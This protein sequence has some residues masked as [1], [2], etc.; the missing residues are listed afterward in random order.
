V[1][2]DLDRAGAGPGRSSE[3]SSDALIGAGDVGGREVPSF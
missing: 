3:G 1:R 2:C